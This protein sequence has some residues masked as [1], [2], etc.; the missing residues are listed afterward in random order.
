MRLLR[1]QR[2]AGAIEWNTARRTETRM[3]VNGRVLESDGCQVDR[4]IYLKECVCK[5]RAGNAAAL[6]KIVVF[7]KRK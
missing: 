2:V 6:R 7:G 1:C 3:G 5:T 4:Y